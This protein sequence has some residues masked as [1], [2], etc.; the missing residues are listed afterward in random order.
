MFSPFFF[1][2]AGPLVRGSNPFRPDVTV[3]SS[4]DACIISLS[5]GTRRYFARRRADE[6]LIYAGWR[7]VENVLGVADPA[8]AAWVKS[9]IGAAT[10]PVVDS[11]WY[12]GPNGENSA[13]RITFDVA[14]SAPSDYSQIYHVF[15]G[16]RWGVASCWVRLVSGG[17]KIYVSPNAATQSAKL[18]TLP[19]GQW[20]RISSD[21]NGVITSAMFYG[22]QLLVSGNIGN[23]YPMV[24]DIATD[25]EHSPQCEINIPKGSPPGENIPPNSFRYFH[26]TN[27]NTVGSDGIVSDTGVR[28]P[29][30]GGGLLVPGPETAH[31]L[32]SNFVVAGVGRAAEKWNELK[33]GVS[34]ITLVGDTLGLGGAIRLQTNGEAGTVGVY[35]A[36]SWS[37]I[38]FSISE[39]DVLWLSCAVRCNSAGTF[40]LGV[41]ITD[42]AFSNLLYPAEDLSGWTNDSSARPKVNMSAGEVRHVIFKLPPVPDSIRTRVQYGYVEC[43][44]T[45]ADF[46]ASGFLV[47][48]RP[49]TTIVVNGGTAGPVARNADIAEAPFRRNTTLDVSWTLD[50]RD[51]VPAGRMLTLVDG[52]DAEVGHV[53]LTSSGNLQVVQ[54]ATTWT[55]AASVPSGQVAVNVALSAGSGGVRA[56]IAGNVETA[57]A[58]T[59]DF[60]AATDAFVGHDASGTGHS[61]AVGTPVW[62]YRP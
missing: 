32:N 55:S 3:G 56:S 43:H 46:E 34:S 10:A 58:P 12:P 25:D 29:I 23:T 14:G 35:Q 19:A 7:R 21:P 50:T 11:G 33:P 1:R 17:P 39:G 24:I 57:G 28:A 27:P 47:S 4:G 15:S 51:G 59:F 18:V 44:G 16:Q 9:A 54:G 52:N 26:Y 45:S 2:G 61:N 41:A 42:N 30:V 36:L 6:K 8:D 38:V 48:R 40:K 62:G 49:P 37:G 20:V 5:D 60:I 13:R 53:D 22:I 31:Y